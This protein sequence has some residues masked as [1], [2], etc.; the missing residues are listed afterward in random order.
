MESSALSV[1][2]LKLFLVALG[3]LY[4]Y[5]LKFPLVPIGFLAV[6]LKPLF[7]VALEFL[8]GNLLALGLNISLW[9]YIS[10]F[11]LLFILSRKVVLEVSFCYAY[12]VWY[13]KFS[14]SCLSTIL[15]FNYFYLSSSFFISANFWLR[16]R[17][18][19][20]SCG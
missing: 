18:S 5:V 3:I 15:M 8:I 16:K 19:S 14:L 6:A 11:R 13:F 17:T 4:P 2:V 7:L 20:L 10:V 9:S 1:V 12:I